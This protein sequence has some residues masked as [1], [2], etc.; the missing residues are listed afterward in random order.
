V[1]RRG[2]LHPQLISCTAALAVWQPCLCYLYI[3]YQVGCEV[4]SVEVYFHAVSICSAFYSVC[5]RLHIVFSV[6][7]FHAPYKTPEDRRTFTASDENSGKNGKSSCVG[8]VKLKS[9]LKI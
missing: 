2:L 3:L 8:S 4:S 9:L 7:L 1:V 6:R 5:I